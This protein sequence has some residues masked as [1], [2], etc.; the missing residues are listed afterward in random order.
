MDTTPALVKK[1]LPEKTIINNSLNNPLTVCT[2][3]QRE[4]RD[5]K[6]TE[7]LVTVGKVGISTEKKTVTVCT[8]TEG[9]A[10][11]EKSTETLVTVGKVGISVSEK[12]TEKLSSKGLL[13]ETLTL[14]TVG[15]VGI[16]T[17]KKT[18]TL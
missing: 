1:S 2:E 6:S 4:A 16:S 17:E 13:T 9:E 18:E 8:E 3:M 12:K 11:E 7:M 10:R 15:K 5:E 14:V